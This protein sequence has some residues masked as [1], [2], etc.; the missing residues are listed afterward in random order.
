[1]KADASIANELTR[2]PWSEVSGPALARAVSVLQ[3]LPRNQAFSLVLHALGAVA[4]RLPERKNGRAVTASMLRGMLKDPLLQDPDGNGQFLITDL[5][6]SEVNYRNMPFRLVAGSSDLSHIKA[7]SLV[8][9]IVKTTGASLPPDFVRRADSLANG[10]FGISEEM[11]RRAG[12]DR[13]HPPAAVHDNKIFVPATNHIRALE[14]AVQFRLDQL[15]TGLMDVLKPMTTTPAESID[16]YPSETSEALAT[17]PFNVSSEHLTISCPG[18]LATALT[19]E[20]Q[21]LAIEYGC[22]PELGR[23]HRRYL[24]LRLAH[25]ASLSALEVKPPVELAD[26]N[27]SMVT[28]HIQGQRIVFAVVADAFDGYSGQEPFGMWMSTGVVDAVN[29]AVC[30]DV[31]DRPVVVFA[32]AS[33]TRGSMGFLSSFDNADWLMLDPHNLETLLKLYWNDDPWELVRYARASS[34]LALTSQV[35][36]ESTLG[37][38][39]VYRDNSDSFYLD[40]N[41]MPSAIVVSGDYD[42]DIRSELRVRLDEHLVPAAQGALTSISRAGT[43]FGPVYMLF[44]DS[45]P[46][47]SVELDGAFI[48]IRASSKNREAFEFYLEGV[49]YWVWQVFSLST[50]KLPFREL[51]ILIR[52][53]AGPGEAISVVR[54]GCVQFE[55]TFRPDVA[56]GSAPESNAFDR[57]LVEALLRSIFQPILDP[58]VDLK[59][60]LETIAPWGDKKM[61]L[62]G[63]GSIPE[64]HDPRMAEHSRLIAKS[65]MSAVLD[66]LGNRLFRGSDIREGDVPAGETVAVLNKS[67]DVLFRRLVDLCSSFESD[68]MLTR[69]IAQADGLEVSSRLDGMRRLTRV[70]CYGEQHYPPAKIR[71]EQSRRVETSLAVRF[72]IEY[73]SASPSSGLAVPSDDEHDTLCALALE[74]TTKGMLSDARH[75]GLS[76]VRLSR[77]GSGRL[78]TTQGD[79]YA[80]GLISHS[81]SAIS[82]ELQGNPDIEDEGAGEWSF[83]EA[84]DEAFT[85][86]FGFTVHEMQVG[87]VTLYDELSAD[88]NSGVVETNVREAAELIA[89][90]TGWSVGRAEGLIDLFALRSIAKFALGPETAP[91]RFGRR[92]SYLRKPI[93]VSG[94]GDKALVRWGQA[95]LLSAVFDLVTLYRTGRLKAESKRMKSLLGSVRQANNNAF[96]KRV[97][98]RFRSRGFQ[99]VRERVRD[100]EGDKL[101]DG[102]GNDLGDIDIL[103][104]DRPRREILVV[105]AKDFETA[106]TPIE[107][108]REMEKL[109]T[110]AVS[111]NHRRAEWVRGRTNLFDSQDSE[112]ERKWSVREIVVTSRRSTAMATGNGHETVVSINDL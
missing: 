37:E 42:L 69:L 87:L 89:V 90:R 36:S 100:V 85:A 84:E 88:P 62:I 78:G 98:E 13:T 106:R 16:I 53:E 28:S 35:I 57:T 26:L 83:T 68:A 55:I 25:T 43:D 11:C 71:E 14:N 4:V 80:T 81:E 58:G 3:L 102:E 21:R 107:M 76:D 22:L 56:F 93:V 74:I 6:C 23:V 111:K 110:D 59:D 91:W 95:R 34:K 67:V 54:Q 103:V 72:L 94:E 19:V 97:A 7:E 47:Y 44:G 17:R 31:Q 108:S 75:Y 70:A 1:M 99:E 9:A 38:F 65:V 82:R 5:F 104:V 92:R 48:W 50:K 33:T 86:E 101:I 40:D 66:D 96:E 109:R 45:A 2:R 32:A 10:V 51:R 46:S 8:Q 112:K 79:R 77:L 20:L 73:I 24:A 12:I 41:R 15:P 30:H 39:G 29:E 63:T 61:F 64:L 27:V 49:A 18:E 60:L 105:E 52:V